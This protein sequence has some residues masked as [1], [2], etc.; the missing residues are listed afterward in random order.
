MARQHIADKQPA[1]IAQ[2]R[3][4][5][6]AC[7]LT[8]GAAFAVA[9]AT[10]PGTSPT[11]TSQEIKSSQTESINMADSDLQTIIST[12]NNYVVLINVF[13]V[14]PENQQKLADILV[15]MHRDVIADVSGFHLRKCPYESRWRTG[16][17]LC[18][19]HQPRCGQ[20]H[21]REQCHGNIPRS[22]SVGR[23]SVQQVA[24]L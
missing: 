22:S 9:T 21:A 8:G 20:N 3:R 12:Q 14:L 18:P 17:R 16:H 24:S 1:A 6:L 11:A 13:T 5:I 15:K 2:S 10:L 4:T 7:G 23:G 19:I